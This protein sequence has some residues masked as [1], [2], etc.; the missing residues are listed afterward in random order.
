MA[1]IVEKLVL[2]FGIDLTELQSGLANADKVLKENSE[3]IEKAADKSAES[4]A[5]GAQKQNEAIESTKDKTEELKKANE[6]VAS[7]YNELA[8]TG[9]DRL[10]NLA[11]GFAAPLTAAIGV[12]SAISN[13]FSEA[14]E[15]AEM[16][17]QYSMQL[18]EWRKKRAMLS[19]ITQED[20]ELYKK[21]RE[22]LTKFNIVMADLGAFITRQ[23]APA[24]KML[25]GWLDKF[26]SWVD[27]NK[28]NISRFITV[29]A[30]T[31]GVLLIPTILKLSAALLANPITWVVA[32]VMALIV[33]IDDLITYM[34]G[35]KSVLGDF[36]KDVIPIIQA[37]ITVVKELYEFIQRTGL[38]EVAINNV[39][40]SFK[41]IIGIIGMI[42]NVLRILYNLFTGDFDGMKQAVNDFNARFQQVI[43]A[44]GGM[45]TNVISVMVNA[46]NEFLNLFGLSFDTIKSWGDVIKDAFSID[47]LIN[48]AK[49]ALAKF[50]DWMPDFFKSDSMAEWAE[51]TKDISEQVNNSSSVSNNRTA[52][53]N[54]N[55]T[56][57]NNITIN[58]NSDPRA[59]ANAV[60][61]GIN[62]NQNSFS[63]MTNSYSSGQY[64]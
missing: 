51:K 41:A 47:K 6:N 36:W 26:S 48:Q 8:K 10:K 19:R 25:L 23:Q 61:N 42:A 29:L 40:L 49:Q 2:A 58:T 38:I 20:I 63:Q 16:T 11:L 3:S 64:M 9:V 12:A 56:Q 39:K 35:G 33:V 21:G 53:V 59:V 32:G 43:T 44:I 60:N 4:V 22:S 27:K 62:Q 46:F 18:E 50:I 13:Y 15:V 45:F 57:N 5:K 34:R 54:N 24:I 31:I 30:S 28:Q 52:N 55:S 1:S 17:G 37:V 7:S 14:G